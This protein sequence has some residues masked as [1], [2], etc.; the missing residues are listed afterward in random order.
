MSSASSISVTVRVRPFTIREAAQL[1][2]LDDGPTFFG[3]GSLASTPQPKITGKG[4]RR[5]VKVIDDRV[6]VFDPPEDNPMARYQKTILPQG[7][8]VKDMRFGFDK[9]F[10]ENTTQE[11]VYQATAKPLLD[12]VLDGFNATVFA[13]GATGCGKTHTISGTPQQPG[14]IFLTCAEL[15]ERIQ[16]VADEKEVDLTL[17]YLEIYNETIRDLLIPGGS[18]QGLALREDSC[19]NI[20]VTGLSTHSPKTVEEVMDMILMGNTNRTMSPTEA[21]AT[22]SRSHAVLQI[23]V[24]QKPR[25]AGLSENHFAATLSIIDLAGSERASVTKNRGER[26]LE[27]ANIN[28]SLLAL[29]NCINALCDPSRKNHVPYRDSKLTRLLKF[30]LGGNCKTVMI[31]CVSPS[32][33][34]YDETHNTLKYA[35]RAKNIKTK[36]SRNM[37]NVNRHVSQYVKAIYDLRQEV[38]ELKKR[39]GDST[40][41]AMD[42]INK[43]SAAKQM[44]L[45]DGVKRLKASFEQSKDLRTQR[46]NDVKGLRL[47]D[48]RIS[49]VQAWLMAFDEVFSTRKNDEPPM[50]LFKMRHEAEKVLRELEHN[51]HYVQERIGT[52]GWEKSLESA[53]QTGVKNLQSIEGVTETDMA[54]LKCEAELLKAMGEREILHAIAESDSDISSSVH[55]LAK[56]HFEIVTT[57]TQLMG[58]NLVEGEAMEAAKKSLFEMQQG[59][60][61]A[62]SHIIKPGGELVSTDTYQSAPL[63]TPR[64]R[65]HNQLSVGLGTPLKPPQFDIAAS[66]ASP[67]KPSPKSFRVKTPK[68]AVKFAK[69][70]KRVRW[71]DEME[72]SSL[73]DEPKRTRV[74]EIPVIIEEYPA[75]PLIERENSHPVDEPQGIVAPPVRPRNNRMEMGFLSKNRDA[76]SMSPADVSFRSHAPL[77]TTDSEQAVNRAKAERDALTDMSSSDESRPWRASARPSRSAMRKS[78]AGTIRHSTRRRSPSASNQ[79]SPDAGLF[80][81]GHAKRMPKSEKDGNGSMPSVL[82]PKSGGIKASARRMT[83]SGTGNLKAYG[84]AILGQIRE[85]GARE[86][87]IGVGGKRVWR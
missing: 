66:A 58:S 23:N 16:A 70:P 41:E 6:L 54:A 24:T 62:V 10:D 17:S 68:K 18:K 56:A 67:A 87:S 51:R 48:M 11:D 9:V 72:E 73:F 49:L 21:N 78:V 81:L 36:V 38:E 61:D 64:Q 12:N 32:S 65:K 14:I 37:I 57:L 84:V 76:S 43:Q 5:V 83:V 29:G 35:N 75:P 15:F 20:S 69:K 7:K 60:A 85:S 33:M 50:H 3:D 8:R 1:T 13:Y 74:A 59:A 2:R 79:Q 39:L 44:S 27:G 77:A 42:K 71:Q 22:S 25:T 31:V 55:T 80:K 4:L 28:R 82:S 30:S 45:Q 40:K 46:I 52:L 47:L 63:S 26:L 19:Q 86:S 53:F 34:H